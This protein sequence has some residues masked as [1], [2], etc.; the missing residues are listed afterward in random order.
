MCVIGHQ[1]PLREQRKKEEEE[2]LKDIYLLF[3]YLFEN[4]SSELV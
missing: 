4:Q 1:A 3:V 2:E